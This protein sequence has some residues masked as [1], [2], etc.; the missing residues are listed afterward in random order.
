MPMHT[1]YA[2]IY[3]SAKAGK[4][5]LLTLKMCQNHKQGCKNLHKDNAV[6]SIKNAKMLPSSADGWTMG[7]AVLLR[8]FPFLYTLLVPHSYCFYSQ[9][10]IAIR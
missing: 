1:L 2:S 10:F 7:C 4:N 8:R 6:C 5:A 3:T 9:E